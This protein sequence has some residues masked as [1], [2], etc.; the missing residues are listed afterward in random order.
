MKNFDEFVAIDWSGAQTPVKTKSISVALCWQG[1][2]APHLSGRLWSRTMV[3]DWICSL[4]ERK[5][6][7]TLVGIDCNFSYSAETC[8][9]QFGPNSTVTDLWQAVEAA[10]TDQPN[11]FAGGYWT[12]GS[13][14]R[15]FW[16]SGKK[17]EGFVMP[18]RLTEQVCGE[19]GF[20]W[21]ESPF[22]LIGPKQVGK[23]GL[24][25][26][27]LLLELKRR[28]GSKIAVWPFDENTDE[29]RL[30]IAEIY[31]RLFLR[32]FG[33][34]NAKIRDVS[35]LNRLLGELQTD[36]YEDTAPFSDHDADAL[37]G[38]AGLRM[39][40]GTAKTVSE[41]LSSPPAPRTMLEREGWI[42]GVGA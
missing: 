42:F 1:R 34:G 28:L 18:R 4:V 36:A 40:C 14:A 19:N 35:A 24:S 27:R 22:K 16:T 8:I 26:M 10:N 6:K 37:V 5:S 23:G 25:G 41:T 9:K 3:A 12:H 7:R 15:Y 29:A 38:A 21:P 30:V 13:H 39:L 17:P 32:R 33:H 20:G 2:A 31:P 11:Y